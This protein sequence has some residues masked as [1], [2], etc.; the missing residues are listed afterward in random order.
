M[1]GSLITYYG[2]PSA[3]TYTCISGLTIIVKG[4]K[5]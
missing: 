4:K 1:G 2:N 5:R 3:D